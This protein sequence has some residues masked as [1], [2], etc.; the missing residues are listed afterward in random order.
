MNK[1]SKKL[2]ILEFVLIGVI[3]GTT[4]D[5]LAVI[6]AT[7]ADFTWGILWI[8]LMVSIPFAFISELV[9]DHPKFWKIFFK[10]GEKK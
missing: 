4:E 1:K 5:L 6:L 3:M 9:V 2:R 10:N 8:V 7:D